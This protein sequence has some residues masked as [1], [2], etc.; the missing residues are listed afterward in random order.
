MSV[1]FCLDVRSIDRVSGSTYKYSVIVPTGVAGRTGPWAVQTRASLVSGGTNYVLFSVNGASAFCNYPSGGRIRGSKF[2]WTTVPNTLDIA[3]TWPND[4]GGDAVSMIEHVITL[5]FQPIKYWNRVFRPMANE[6]TSYSVAIRSA[7]RISGDANT[8]T[9]NLPAMEQGRYRMECHACLATSAGL[10][11]L[12]VQGAGIQPLST[13]P[14]L[15]W[16]SMFCY[17]NNAQ[18]YPCTLYFSSIP[19]TLS[20]RH[21]KVSTNAVTTTTP[22][23]CF[24]MVFT[25]LKIKADAPHLPPTK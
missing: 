11:E 24:I 5:E 21:V 4:G 23:C 15:A 1:S 7:D 20:F 2:I 9:V 13:S 17:V 6:V 19:T 18:T 12:Q 14:G 25:K 8:F 16:A 10:A 3:A 22:E